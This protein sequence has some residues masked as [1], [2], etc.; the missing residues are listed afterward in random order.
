MDATAVLSMALPAVFVVVGIVLIVLLIEL[1]RAVKS[2]RTTVDDVKQQIEPTLEHVEYITRTL[3]PAIDKVDPLVDRVSLTLDAA[4]LE[5]M[6]VD[7]ILEDVTAI[8]DTASS[9]VAAVDSVANAPMNAVKSVSGKVRS[10]FRMKSISDET[11]R[12]ER[13][14]AATARALEQLK[15]EERKAGQRASVSCDDSASESNLIADA[16]RSAS[17]V[18]VHDASKLDGY[19]HYQPASSEKTA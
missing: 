1:Y 7:Q 12:L 8:S 9:A 3:R 11:A 16:G 13:Q 15:G 14:R 5:L 4:N 6:R 10:V 2:L 18:S 17:D 19:F